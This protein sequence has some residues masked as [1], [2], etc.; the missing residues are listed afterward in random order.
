L[1]SDFKL[2]E[3][4]VADIVGYILHQEE[5]DG[6]RLIVQFPGVDQRVG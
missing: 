2:V 4:L 6:F 1:F 3:L 5:Y